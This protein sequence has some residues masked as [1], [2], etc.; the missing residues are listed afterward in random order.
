[1]NHLK[2]ISLTPRYATICGYIDTV[3]TPELGGLDRDKIRQWYYGYDWRAAQRLYC[4][5]DVLLLFDERE[6][7]PYWFETA[8]PSFLFEVQK[9]NRLVQSNLKVA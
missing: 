1:M 2:D 9:I 8:S 7:A 4:P 3:F 6:F 5:F